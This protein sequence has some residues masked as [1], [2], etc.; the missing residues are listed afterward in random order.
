VITLGLTLSLAALGMGW[1]T[2]SGALLILGFW[3]FLIVFGCLLAR[4]WHRYDNSVNR[5]LQGQLRVGIG[6][7]D[8]QEKDAT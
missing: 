7:Y 5:P 2:N 8:P 4:D 6:A 1:A 3:A